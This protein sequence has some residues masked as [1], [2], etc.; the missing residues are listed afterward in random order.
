MLNIDTIKVGGIRFIK[1]GRLTLS[2]CA[3]TRYKP[4]KRWTREAVTHMCEY[5]IERALGV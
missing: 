2:F 4:F 3:S 5:A 1:I